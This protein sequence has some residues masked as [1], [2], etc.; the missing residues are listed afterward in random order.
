MIKQE[1]VKELLRHV[2]SIEDKTLEIGLVSNLGYPDEVVIALILAQ[3]ENSEDPDREVVVPDLAWAGAILDHLD[4][5]GFVVKR[6]KIK[7]NG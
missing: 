2:R 3:L 4:T 1:N 5:Q 7:K 6:K